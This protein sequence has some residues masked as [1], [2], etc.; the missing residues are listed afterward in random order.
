MNDTFV[1]GDYNV[2]TDCC[3]RKRKA[4]QC[5]MKWDGALVCAEHWEPRHPQ[6]FAGHARPEQNDVPISRPPTEPVYV[7]SSV[8]DFDPPD[9]DTF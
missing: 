5:R 7:S 6:D 3:G 1:F 8:P 4:S 2:I 9:P